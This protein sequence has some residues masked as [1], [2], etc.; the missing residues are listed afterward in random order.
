MFNLLSGD[1]KI[2]FIS[3]SWN[4]SHDLIDVHLAI[5]EI[6]TESCLIE[7]FFNVFHGVGSRIGWKWTRLT[8]WVDMSHVTDWWNNL[9]LVISDCIVDLLV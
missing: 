5:M 1:L 3:Y 7:Y 6:L 9:I 2:K 8:D 4:S